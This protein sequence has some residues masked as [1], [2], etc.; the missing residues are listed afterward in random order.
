MFKEEERPALKG[1]PYGNAE[2]HRAE[3]VEADVRGK[4]SP[5]RR[6]MNGLR[7]ITS[8]ELKWEE[9]YDGECEVE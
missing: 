6:I 4:P 9:G 8:C 2:G 1:G 3:G 7:G 5:L